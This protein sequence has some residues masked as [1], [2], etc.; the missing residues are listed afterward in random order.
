VDAWVAQSYQAGGRGRR[1]ALETGAAL[2]G[3]EVSREALRAMNRHGQ[4]EAMA[5]LRAT[6]QAAAEVQARPDGALSPEV[7]QAV[8]GKLDAKTAQAFVGTQGERDLAAFVAV[9]LATHQEARPEDFRRAMAGAPAGQGE[10]APGRAVPRALGLDPAA[11]G[12]HFAAMNRFARMSEQAGLSQEQ[13]QQLLREVGQ[14][15]KVSQPL[16]REIE[17]AIRKQG[18]K[19]A[20]LSVEDL[21]ARAQALPPTLR[22]PV[23]VHLPG[24][25][26]KRRPGHE[27]NKLSD[28]ELTGRRGSRPSR[29]VTQTEE[30]S[31]SP[32]QGRVAPPALPGRVGG[33]RS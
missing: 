30:Q 22:G 25:A 29:Q 17:A 20:G 12:Q 19:A 3:E 5:A 32:A 21:E 6:R 26:S 16:R 4:E 7:L 27:S 15:G 10:G 13:R 1:Q 9:G 18:D 11:A 33:K 14:N 24:T 2:V 23:E 8:R 31:P 28:D